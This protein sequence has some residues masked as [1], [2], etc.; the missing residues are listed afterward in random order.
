MGRKYKDL[1]NQKFGELTAL[2]IDDTYV[3][4]KGKSKKWLCNCSCGIVV[5]VRA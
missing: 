1:S 4:G 2:Y 3:G 5:S